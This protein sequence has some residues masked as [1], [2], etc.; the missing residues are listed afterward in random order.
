MKGDWPL[1]TKL[2]LVGGHEGAGV[3]VALGENVKGWKVGDYAG[4]KWLNGS[5]LNCEYCQS[6]AEPN[7]AEADLSGYTHDG[8]F[9]NMLLLTLFKLP[10]S[11]LVPT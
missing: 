7:C 3:V 6:G 9:N 2:P 8:S 11:Q 10:E 1:A 4:V 5:C